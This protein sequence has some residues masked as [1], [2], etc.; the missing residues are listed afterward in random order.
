MG[1]ARDP[2][3]AAAA[4]E[5]EEQLQRRLD[6][7]EN[8]KM[9]PFER[10][11]IGVLEDIRDTLQAP[12]LPPVLATIDPATPGEVR[13]RIQRSLPPG[14]LLTG[15]NS[16]ILDVRPL[17]GYSLAS[18]PTDRLFAVPPTVTNVVDMAGGPVADP[19]GH[20]APLLDAP[21]EVLGEALDGAAEALL[22]NFPAIGDERAARRFAEVA[23]DAAL[24]VAA[25]IETS[26]VP[27]TTT[28]GAAGG[29]V[30]PIP[31]AD[32]PTSP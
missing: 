3:V 7:Q 28:D 4:A 31:P 21:P 25:A 14:S 24:T 26:V 27:P 2:S 18:I 1:W 13:H 22:E 30:P 10:K 9:T 32:T 16:P 11:L 6:A 29:D 8:A 15:P 12:P 23:L 19:D 20:F 17:G 5:A